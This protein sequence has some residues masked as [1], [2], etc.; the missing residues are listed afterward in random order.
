MSELSVQLRVFEGWSLPIMVLD[1][2]LRFIFANEA[3]LKVVHKTYDDIDGQYVFDAFPESEQRTVPILSKF[4]TALNG[5]VTQLCTQPFKLKL[6]NGTFEDHVWKA[7]QDPLY[8]EHGDI[9]GI[10][11]RSADITQQHQLEQRNKAIGYELSHRVKNIMAVVRSVARI[12]GRNASRV[13]DFTV[14]DFIKTFAARLNAMSRTNDLLEEVDWSGLDVHTIFSDELSPFEDSNSAT[15]SLQG[16][17]VRLSVDASKD[18]SMVC[19]E[20]MTNAVKY[21]CLGQDDGYLDVI[22]SRTGDQLTIRWLEQ[23]SEVIPPTDSVGFGTQLFD[24]LPYVTVDR[25]YT[26]TGLHLTITMDGEKVFA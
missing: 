8:N 2:D 13:P 25:H 14:H 23:H 10:I 5:E 16:P 24:M 11:Q 20:L 19:H 3:Y 12:T 7:T 15:Y 21:G 18:L 26:P 22:W 9:I 1:T 17:L 4:Q 6:K